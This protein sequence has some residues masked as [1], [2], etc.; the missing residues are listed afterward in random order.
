[1]TEDELESEGWVADPYMKT[2]VIILNNGSKIYPSRD[3]EGNGP[4]CVFGVS[5]QGEAF[6]LDIRG[7]RIA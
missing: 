2:P 3:P 6:I 5:A 1:M 7:E 4:G